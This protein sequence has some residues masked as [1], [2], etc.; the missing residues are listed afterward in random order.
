LNGPQ[1]GGS[2]G[3]ADVQGPGDQDGSLWRAFKGARIREKIIWRNGRG[4]VK[5]GGV[6]EP[7]AQIASSFYMVKTIR[8]RTQ[9]NRIKKEAVE[10]R[11]RR[12][13]NR[14]KCSEKQAVSSQCKHSA[15]GID[16]GLG[17]GE[18][19]ATAKRIS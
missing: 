7:L 14:E 9:G 1:G 2:R 3:R 12:V 18:G 11:V 5:A 8:G 10:G 17:E 13:R 6:K 4:Q 19:G 15:R 16:W